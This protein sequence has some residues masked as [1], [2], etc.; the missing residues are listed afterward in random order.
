MANCNKCAYS[1][2]YWNVKLQTGGSQCISSHDIS[3]ETKE[4]EH[5]CPAFKV[6]EWD[7]KRMD[8]QVRNGD[9]IWEEK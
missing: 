3:M 7:E 4:G 2:P 5:D 1:V 6:N 9:S 8:A